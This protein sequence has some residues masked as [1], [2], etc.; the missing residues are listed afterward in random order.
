MSAETERHSVP[1]LTPTEGRLGEAEGLSRQDSGRTVTVWPEKGQ[2][3][4]R[5]A[6]ERTG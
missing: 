4:E 6:R 3:A 1:F 5:T 2:E